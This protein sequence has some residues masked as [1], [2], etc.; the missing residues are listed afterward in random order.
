[1]TGRYV[2]PVCREVEKSSKDPEFN[3]ARLGPDKGALLIFGCNGAQCWK[4]HEA[5]VAAIKAGY[6]NVAWFC[7]GVPEWRSAGLPIETGDPLVANPQHHEY[8]LYLA[9]EDIDHTRTRAKSPQTNGIVELQRV[10]PH[11]VPQEDLR[12][13]RRPCRPTSTPGLTTT[14]TG[15]SINIDGVMARH[16]CAPS[17]TPS[18]WSRRTHRL[19]LITHRRI[20][21]CV[22]SCPGQYN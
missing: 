10:L 5:S 2:D 4:S 9:L 7:S 16:P 3:V 6:T 20:R 18:T 14:T 22:R 19:P 21:P 12:H 11:R 17:S 13:H 15:A 8:E 1:M